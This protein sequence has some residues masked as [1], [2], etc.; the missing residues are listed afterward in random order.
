MRKWL[1]LVVFVFLLVGCS[2]NR[3]DMEVVPVDNEEDFEAA[4]E[5]VENYKADMTKSVGNE[6]FDYLEDYLIPNNSYYHSLRRYVSDLEQ[7]KT[8]KELVDF[9]VIEVLVGEESE[10][11]VEANEKVALSYQNG[12]VEEVSRHIE[13]ELVRSPEGTFRIVT[14]RQFKD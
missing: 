10:Y 6:G 9:E 13:F 5:F 1:S 4:A 14:I 3:S 11:Y 7:S 12:E 8:T 2:D